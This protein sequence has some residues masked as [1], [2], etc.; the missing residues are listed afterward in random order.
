MPTLR[1]CGAPTQASPRRFAGADSPRPTRR[2][3]AGP[4]RGWEE[5][6][7]LLDQWGAPERSHR[8]KAR[9]LAEQQ[10]ADPLAW[11]VQAIVRSYELA[12]GLREVGEK[13]D[14]TFSVSVSKTVAVPI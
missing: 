11:N 2:S 13:D 12:R 7:D 5:W 4:S 9:W 6:F 10:G 3:A 14:G 8:E 1:P